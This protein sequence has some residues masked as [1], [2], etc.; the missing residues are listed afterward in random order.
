LD[1]DQNK[2]QHTNIGVR[3][4]CLRLYGNKAEAWLS[5]QG[6]DKQSISVL[7]AEASFPRCS[8]GSPKQCS[9]LPGV[10]TIHFA[11]LRFFMSR[12]CILSRI[13]ILDATSGLCLPAILWSA[14]AMLAPLW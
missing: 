3:K 11:K 13:R 1:F 8:I 4:P 7:D 10:I 2:R 9:L 5:C 12:S 6:H 14:Q